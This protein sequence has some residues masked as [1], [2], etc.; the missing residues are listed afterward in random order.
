MD[1]LFS[2]VT[3]RLCVGLLYCLNLMSL[4][5]RKYF[6]E[7]TTFS[8]ER[9]SIQAVNEHMSRMGPLFECVLRIRH[10]SLLYACQHAALF[11]YLSLCHTISTNTGTIGL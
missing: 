2:E 3:V 4:V 5:I 7:G 8:I 1:F 9:H 6:C 10:G 11:M